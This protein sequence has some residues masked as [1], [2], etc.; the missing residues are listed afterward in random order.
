[1]SVKNKK[2]RRPWR[3][4]DSGKREAGVRLDKALND[5]VL[6]AM[7]FYPIPLEKWAR[8]KGI[9]LEGGWLR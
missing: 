6:A 2:Y 5:P 9:S 1:M 7:I 4:T 3:R 8:E